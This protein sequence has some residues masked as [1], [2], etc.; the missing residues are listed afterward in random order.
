M[1]RK[2]CER[3]RLWSNLK[4]Y[5]RISPEGLKKIEKN[6]G[7]EGQCSGR[8]SKKSKALP[9]EPTYSITM[10]IL[11]GDIKRNVNKEVLREW[12]GFIWVRVGIGAGIC[13]YAM[14]LRANNRR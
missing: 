2:G 4:F 10:Y 14:K 12:I 9:L 6:L 8:D 1:Y 5:P 11:K 3:K 7:R 13:E